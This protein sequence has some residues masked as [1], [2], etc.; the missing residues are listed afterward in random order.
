MSI[1]F[2]LHFMRTKA[3]SLFH[4]PHAW[5]HGHSAGQC[6]CTC[7]LERSERRPVCTRGRRTSRRLPG[8]QLMPAIDD[9]AADLRLRGRRSQLLLKAC[10]C[11]LF[12]CV[13]SRSHNKS[14]SL[15]FWF[16]WLVL[17]QLRQHTRPVTKQQERNRQVLWLERSQKS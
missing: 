9:W 10:C 17:T 7:R 15:C 8:S 11:C 4:A 5:S 13:E 2:L 6:A 3:A 12:A 1:V 16:E 14:R